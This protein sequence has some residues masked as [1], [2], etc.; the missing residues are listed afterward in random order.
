MRG[1]EVDALKGME[2][3]R[4]ICGRGEGRIWGHEGGIEQLDA[5][6]EY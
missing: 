3:G 4:N 6:S 5:T 1:K 2:E